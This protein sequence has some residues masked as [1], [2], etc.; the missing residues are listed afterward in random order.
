M[1]IFHISISAAFAALTFSHVFQSKNIKALRER[2]EKMEKALA[3]TVSEGQAI[4]MTDQAKCDV[5][6]ALAE[7][8]NAKDDQQQEISIA[9]QL[10]EHEQKALESMAHSLG[11]M[12]PGKFQTLHDAVV[13]ERE[14]RKNC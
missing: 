5:L 3:G 9:D 13:C 14:R 8:S 1:D 4:A 7:A 6:F 2:G 10:K 12:D 11:T